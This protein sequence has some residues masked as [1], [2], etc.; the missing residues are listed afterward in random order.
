MSR[1][2]HVGSD[3]TAQMVDVSAKDKSV[4]EATAVG[5][6]HLQSNTIEQ[7]FTGNL[8]KGD[9]L[10]VARIAAV[11][12]AKKTSD[13]IPLCHPLMIDHA[14]V[15]FTRETQSIAINV[16]IR[17][18]GRTGVEMEAL[19]AVSVGLLTLYD[20]VKAIEREAQIDGVAL[21]KKTGG[22]S[23]SWTRSSR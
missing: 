3:G 15:E 11:Q 1:L 23:G 21:V 19:A 6:I 12:A 18:T 20:M 8:P 5:R 2:T 14:Q 17:C 13:L 4:R 9:A 7:V 22:R 16:T 10:T